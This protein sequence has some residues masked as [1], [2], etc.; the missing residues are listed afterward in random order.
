MTCFLTYI[1]DVS[2]GYQKFERIFQKC[3]KSYLVTA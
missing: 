2:L 1:R 3:E